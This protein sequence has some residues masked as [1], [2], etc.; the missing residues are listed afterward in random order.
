MIN[1]SSFYKMCFLQYTS[2]RC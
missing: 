2:C 1:F